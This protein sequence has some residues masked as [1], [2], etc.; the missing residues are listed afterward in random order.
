MN[1]LNR[2]SSLFRSKLSGSSVAEISWVFFGQVFSAGLGFVILKL[3]S[4]LGPENFGIYTLVLTIAAFIG[5][6]FF[7]PLQQGFIRF[8]HHYAKKSRVDIYLK[9]L[10]KTLLWMSIIF[11]LIA[12]LA[13]SLSSAFNLYEPFYFLALAGIFVITFK[14]SE[15]FNGALN[16]L[17]KR[18]EYSIILTLEKSFIILLLFLL[19]ITDYLNLDNVL[20]ALTL[21]AIIFGTIKILIFSKYLPTSKPAAGEDLN[22]H[23]KEIQTKLIGYIFPFF[24][25]GLSGWLLLNGEKWII[26]GLLSTVDVGIYAIMLALVNAF[27][28]VPNN[29]I[30]EFTTPI[31]F[32]HYA[33]LNDS[34]RIKAGYDY[35]KLTIAAV[36]FI[37]IISS[38]IMLIWGKELIILVSNSNYS[39]YWY[40]LPALCFGTGLFLTGQAQSI[41]GMALNQPMKYL[42]PKVTIG[43]L[44]VILNLVLIKIYGLA[45]VAYSVL[46]T[47]IIYTLFIFIINRKMIHSVKT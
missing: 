11:T 32:Q 29:I 6:L 12:V 17:R 41:L 19:L 23:R 24:I 43:I 5:L 26:N 37:S 20:I 44:A 1:Y 38:G 15:F 36:L 4:G 40:L 7:G 3:L 47:G 39:A 46:A 10:Y 21:A 31:I 9:L 13:A 42:I 8:Y 28:V 34:E 27:I 2:F 14:L 25:W 33:D 22:V 18:K 30:S 45:G 16:I 35:I